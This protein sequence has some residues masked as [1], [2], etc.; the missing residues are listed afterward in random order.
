VTDNREKGSF[1][2]TIAIEYLKKKGHRIIARNE[3]N[4]FGEID[5]ISVTPDRKI[6]FTEVKYRKSS[7]NGYP[8]EAVTAAKQRK[9]SR[10]SAYYLNSHREY[11][12]HQVRYDCIGITGDEIKH[13]ENA[14]YY[15]G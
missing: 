13:I 5:I 8:L 2:E 6:V 12:N 11:M 3:L 4:K 9:I 1:H 14:F 7:K 10:A 15:V